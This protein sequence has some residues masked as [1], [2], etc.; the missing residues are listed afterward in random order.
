[1]TFG[2][3]APLMYKPYLV[4][5]VGFVSNLVI[6][7]MRSDTQETEEHTL[8]IKKMD[9]NQKIVSNENMMKTQKYP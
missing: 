9:F 7:T 6:T 5:V 8:S 2:A 1:M 3:I 4:H